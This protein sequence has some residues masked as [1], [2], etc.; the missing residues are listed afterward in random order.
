MKLMH[1]RSNRSVRRL[2][3]LRGPIALFAVAMALIVALLV[4]WNVVLAVDYQRIRELA[5]RAT[6]EGAA[7][8]HTTFI[9]LGS[10]LFV[11]AI[12]LLAVLGAQLF[13][14]I[15]FSRRLANFIATFTHELNSP[16][17]SIKLF[18]ET[19]RDT[20]LSPDERRR[21]CDLILADTDRLHGRITNVLRAAVIDGPHGLRLAPR[22]VDLGEVI[23]RDLAA[24]RPRFERCE[25]TVTVCLDCEPGIEV[26][27]DRREFAH[28]LDNLYDNA[29][30]Y[31]RPDGVHIT[32][33]LTRSEAP[34]LAVLEFRDDGMGI[35]AQASG[36]VF[37]RFARAEAH[38]PEAA[39][40]GTG[41]GLWIARAI[42]RA[43]GGAIEARSAG[44]GAGTTIRIELPLAAPVRRAAPTRADAAHSGR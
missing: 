16:L 40:P 41:L 21:F 20:E 13:S 14:E 26:E 38:A 24:R 23:A 34:D 35:D 28:V 44:I 8:F 11:T 12:A 22:R 5:T 39:R 37:E 3:S 4:L 32:I 25:R 27:L 42:V 2:R 33:R 10:V 19:L 17:S 36:V 7:A 30:K 9:A 15:R 31:G 18:A 1:T 29:I 43:H 6:A